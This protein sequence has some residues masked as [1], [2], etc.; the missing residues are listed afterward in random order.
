MRINF[1]KKFIIPILIILSCVFTTSEAEQYKNDKSICVI[2][3]LDEEDNESEKENK[4]DYTKTIWNL[5]S[6]FKNDEQWNN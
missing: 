5:E 4:I 6:L 1:S 3:I 2:N